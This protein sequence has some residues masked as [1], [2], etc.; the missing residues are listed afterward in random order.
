MWKGSPDWSDI[1]PL[2]TK[3]A[4]RF[5]LPEKLAGMRYE[6]FHYSPDGVYPDA[7]RQKRARAFYDFY[8]HLCRTKPREYVKGPLE[9]CDGREHQLRGRW[10][11]VIGPVVI[12]T[13]PDVVPPPA[14][15]RAVKVIPFQPTQERR[16]WWPG[17][18]DEY[19]RTPEYKRIAA[20]ARKEWGYQCLMDVRHRGY[21]EMHHRSYAHV[22][23]GEDWRDL[24]PL[25]EECHRKFHDR[26]VKPPVGL[27]TE[28]APLKKAA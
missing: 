9:I 22:P 14:V 21:V 7:E 3:R 19:T 27:F 4:I 10:D 11:A 18:Y 23:F 8:L 25:C 5:A 28:A 24:I 16:R 15:E 6:V 26:L 1:L 17:T 13:D 12:H 2:A 20:L